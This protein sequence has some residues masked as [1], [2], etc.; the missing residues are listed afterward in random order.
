MSSSRRVPSVAR[1]AHRR[2]SVLLRLR[3][4]HLAVLWA[5]AASSLIGWGLPSARLD[6][7]LFG[8]DPP[9]PPERYPARAQA[10]QLSERSAGADTDLN[11]LER[12]DRLI[13]LTADDTARGEI[14]QRYRLY[15]RQPDE[16]I[17]FRALQRMRPAA[18]D[19][20]P[21]LYQYGGAYIYMV[22]AGLAAA[23]ALG[24]VRLTSDAGVYLAQP[25]LFGAFY[26]TARVATLAF[27]PL[28]LLGVA[29]LARRGGGKAAGWAALLCVAVAPVFLCG[30]LEAKPHLPSACLLLWATLAALDYQRRGRPW[31]ALC[32]GLLVGLAFGFVLTGAVGALL[33]PALL[34]W[35]RAPLRRRAFDL[36]LAA[37]AAA[38]VYVATNP[39]V[40]YNYLFNREAFSSNI[41][42][43]T[44]MYRIGQFHL[45]AWRV[46]ELLFESGGAGLVITGLIAWALLLRE[47]LD[48]SLAAGAAGLGMALLAI[49][50]GAGKPAEFARFLLL[51]TALLAVAA[52]IVLARAAREHRKAAALLALIVFATMP[53]YAYLRSFRND[54]RLDTETRYAAGRYLA[55]QIEPGETVGLLQ[56]PAPF[57]VPPLDFTRLDVLLLP[58]SP[59]AD[60]SAALPDWLV[61]TA[62]DDAPPGAWWRAHYRLR[63]RFPDASERLSP[64][65]WANKAVFVYRRDGVRP[66]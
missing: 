53:T 54:L 9:W 47:R 30:A 58:E 39:Y 12:R 50:I 31:D 5:V 13:V 62:D 45:G 15:S 10:Q 17:T 21:R 60:A 34:Y 65:T 11:P 2:R 59:P 19:L 27:A 51:P 52:G 23:A 33:W 6:P 25:D 43:T 42:N 46:G 16:L 24:L 41:G 4:W 36:G 20:D 55:A 29:K 63:R 40:P 56:E 64:I 48:R 61:F 37:A 3:Y 35:G 18:G 22:G 26:V 1:A 32:V 28:L 57:S 66:P 44:A 7:L 14:L 8:G 38:L 49:A